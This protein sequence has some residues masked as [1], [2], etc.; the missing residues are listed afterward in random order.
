MAMGNMIMISEP[1]YPKE[2][3]SRHP[4]FVK[5]GNSVMACFAVQAKIIIAKGVHEPSKHSIY[6]I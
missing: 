2:C 4:V 3:V 6:S 5:S 1:V